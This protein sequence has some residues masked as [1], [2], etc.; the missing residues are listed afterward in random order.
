M[1]IRDSDTG[2]AQ[3]VFTIT[4]NGQ[5]EKAYSFTKPFVAHLVREEPDLVPW[6][7]Y[8]LTWVTQ[9]TPEVVRNWITQPTA[10]GMLGFQHVKEARFAYNAPQ[11]VTF[12]I[13]IDGVAY[14]YVLPP[15]A[16]YVRST[17]PFGPWKGRVFQYSAVSTA[18]F[19]V[20][21][22]DFALLVKPWGDAGPYTTV[23]LIGGNLG[24]MATI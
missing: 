2:T 23:K 1:T 18:G 7:K 10:H 8:K 6:K 24:P 3:Q 9:P 19:Q 4:H 22:E 20:W 15:T 5:Q 21:V 16:G 13:T 17:I 12:T 14:P 11:P